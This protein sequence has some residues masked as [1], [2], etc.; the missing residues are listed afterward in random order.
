MRVDYLQIY[1][2]YFTIILGIEH[3]LTKAHQWHGGAF[4]WG[5]RRSPQQPWLPKW[6]ELGEDAAAVR[7][8]VQTP[9]A[10]VSPEVQNT[11]ADHEEMVR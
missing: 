5:Y 4:Q 6:A 9:S 7:D 1:T 11:D 8:L 10:P 3:R 2:W